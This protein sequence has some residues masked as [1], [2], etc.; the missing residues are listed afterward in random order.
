MLKF[1][2]ELTILKQRMRIP[3]Q[4]VWRNRTVESGI[5]ALCI[6]LRRLAYPNRLGDITVTFSRPVYELSYIFTEAL[7]MIYEN[8]AHLF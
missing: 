6:L 5:E 2:K 4:I 3:D 8:H 1:Y 7:N